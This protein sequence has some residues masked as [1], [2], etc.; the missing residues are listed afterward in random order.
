MAGLRAGNYNSKQRSREPAAP[1][2]QLPEGGA[3]PGSHGTLGPRTTKLL[4]RVVWRL[5]PHVW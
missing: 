2:N 5:I 1:A 4:L 3:M